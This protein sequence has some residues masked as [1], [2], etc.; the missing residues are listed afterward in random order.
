MRQDVTLATSF[1]CSYINK[2]LICDWVKKF[3]FGSYCV[4]SLLNL[5]NMQSL[6]DGSWILTGYDGDIGMCPYDYETDHFFLVHTD[7]AFNP[8]KIVQLRSGLN[9]YNLQ[10]GR[11]I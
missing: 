1:Y 6:S 5:L 3:N 10:L 8:L 7:T 2:N 11:L 4:I 9:S